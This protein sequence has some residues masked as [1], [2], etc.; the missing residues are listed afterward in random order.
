[1]ENFI[2]GGFYC[3]CPL[4][5]TG[6]TCE[7]KIDPCLSNPCQNGGNCTN[8]GINRFTCNFFKYFT[9]VVKYKVTR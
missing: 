8:N 5:T 3:N 9:M 7:S 2:T 6:A 4:G 1:M